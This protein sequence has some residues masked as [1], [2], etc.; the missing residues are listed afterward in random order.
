MK[1]TILLALFA[2]TSCSSG[3]TKLD[4]TTKFLASN[5]AF[6]ATDDVDTETQ[7]LASNVLLSETTAN[8]QA[9]DVQSA[10]EEIQPTLSTTI[11]GTWTVKGLSLGSDTASESAMPDYTD[12]T[13]TITFDSD[14]SVTLANVIAQD[15]TVFDYFLNESTT[16]L[17]S[18]S[19]NRVYE[20]TDEL[21]LS[22]RVY[23]NQTA[24]DAFVVRNYP[25][26]LVKSESD[27][28]VFSYAGYPYIFTRQ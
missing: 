7:I 24:D 26:V 21:V 15:P 4:T 23:G 27:K 10:L 5:I 1:P 13:A 25:F 16:A 3:Q 2:L 28:M 9:T 22:F 17:T 14:G 8:I 19:L 18:S 20:V 11:V 6:A 12:S